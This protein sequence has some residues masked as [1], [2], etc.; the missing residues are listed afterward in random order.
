MGIK[1][2]FAAFL[3][4]LP[5]V[6]TTPLYA[7]TDRSAQRDAFIMQWRKNQGSYIDFFRSNGTRVFEAKYDPWGVQTMVT[8]SIH[9]HRG[10]GGHEMLNHFGIINMGGRLYDPLLGR[11]L[12]PDNYVQE[13]FN[14]QNL[15]RYSYC[16]NN[17]VKYTDPS[18]NFH[19]VSWLQKNLILGAL[20]GFFHGSDPINSMLRQ[21]KMSTKIVQGLFAT[22]S[23]KSDWGRARELISRFTWQLPQTYLGF[24]TANLLNE[25]GDVGYV[26]SKFGATAV[27]SKTLNKFGAVT[28]G[29]YIIGER[30][31]RADENNSLFQHEYGHYLQ[32]QSLGLGYLVRV[33]AP[34]FLQ[35]SF[36]GNHDFM[37]Y[38]QDAN[39]RAFRY[40]NENVPGFYTSPE[41]YNSQFVE[42]LSAEMK[43]IKYHWPK[44]DF[45]NNPLSLKDKHDIFLWYIDF[46]N[47]LSYYE[48]ARKYRIRLFK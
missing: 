1:N 33:G 34:S 43:G 25:Y 35:A 30:N 46:R 2:L 15:N 6:S 40:F 17:P 16:L 21:V 47:P 24:R 41:E 27:A 44:W 18:G 26:K 37:N 12:S 38:E 32:S 39:M 20:K 9:F 22:D 31:L 5:A 10:Y 36:G 7:F 4:L 45:K 29:N 8:D 14:T 3:L 42:W 19:F 11:F 23:N 28:L 13:P 48:F